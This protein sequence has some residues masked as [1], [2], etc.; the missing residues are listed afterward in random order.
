M[1]LGYAVEKSGLLDIIGRRI[2]D[3]VQDLPVIAISFIFGVLVLV[4]ATFVSHTVAALII[5]PI[6]KQVGQQ[7]S[8]PHPNFLVMVRERNLSVY[9]FFF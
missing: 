2:A 9:A 7:L 8:P 3:G 6:V 4:F 1:A 5:L